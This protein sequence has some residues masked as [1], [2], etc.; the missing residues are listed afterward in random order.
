[1]LAAERPLTRRNRRWLPRALLISAIAGAAVLVPVLPNR[2]PLGD[3]TA[4]CGAERCH[5]AVT[6]PLPPAE[7]TEE[8]L[9]AAL[10]SQ[11]MAGAQL[12]E[13]IACAGSWASFGTEFLGRCDGCGR[14]YRTFWRLAAGVWELIYYERDASCQAVW[15]IDR[16]VPAAI[17][18]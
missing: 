4:N 17:C 3:A 8:S 7:C 18:S 12:V 15:T 9:R 14:E 2:V 11:L 6:V 5:V 10:Q 13:D 16:Q 1:M